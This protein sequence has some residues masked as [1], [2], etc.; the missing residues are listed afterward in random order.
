M[1][2]TNQYIKDFFEKKDRPNPL[3]V[4]TRYGKALESK[5]APNIP[6]CE[7]WVAER[8]RKSQSVANP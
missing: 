6:K 7:E 8:L 3:I 4:K 2:I 1:P 5:F